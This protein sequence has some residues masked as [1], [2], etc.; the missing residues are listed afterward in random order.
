M[1]PA[2]PRMGHPAR[3]M[4]LAVLAVLA[5]GTGTSRA[6]LSRLTADEA[7]RIAL[8]DNNSVY[9]AARQVEQAEGGLKLARSPLL[10]QLNV[11]GDL[12]RSHQGEQRSAFRVGGSVP[13]TNTNSRSGSVSLSQELINLQALN[14]AREAARG[15]AATRA[16]EVSTRQ[17]VAL[18]VKQQFYALVRAKQ[19]S[20]VSVDA[21]RL[22]SSTLALTQGLFDVGTAPRTD[23][24][25]ARTQHAQ[26]RLAV[27]SAQHSVDIERLRL[28]GLLGLADDR[29]LDVV[30]ALPEDVPLPD[31]TNILESAYANRPDLAQLLRQIDAAEAGL[32][33][34]RAARYPTL[35]ASVSIQKSIFSTTQDSLTQ[36]G[37]T[38]KSL[39][40]NLADTSFVPVYGDTIS[41][42]PET[43]F[44]SRPFSWSVGARVTVPIFDGFST[45]GR[46][47]QRAAELEIQRRNLSQRRVEI[48]LEVRQAWLGLVEARERAR[49]A[50]EALDYAEQSHELNREKYRLGSSTLLE[51][52]TAEVQLTRSRSD[53]VDARVGL[54]LARAQLDRALGQNP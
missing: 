32:G 39:R 7:V 27:I 53:L 18:A 44:E 49:V 3:A 13:S 54:Q 28:A 6:D 50:V 15:L 47:Q 25:K 19:L 20:G 11:T 30:D 31:S 14:G 48:A 22:D 38:L 40:L 41:Q 45:K 10:P 8:R 51:L 17:Q 46:I 36:V 26:S 23:L 5:G 43:K 29:G 9:A 34:A 35:G 37:T 42:I 2:P 24:L 4:A 33:S 16:A 52:T 1:I 21:A 12:A